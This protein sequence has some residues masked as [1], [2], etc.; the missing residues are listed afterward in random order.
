VVFESVTATG[1]GRNG[2]SLDGSSLADGPNATGTST[3]VYGNNTVSNSTSSG[4]GRYGIEVI[5]GINVVVTGNNLE[6]NVTGIVV[7]DG[8]SAV[9]LQ[10]NRISKGGDQ[11]ISI[12]NA[13][14]DAIVRNNII[15]GGEVGVYVRDAGGTFE[16]NTIQDVSS[17][18]ITLVGATGISQLVGN[19]ISGSGPTALDVARTTDAEVS[20]NATDDWMSTKPID[21]VLR[22]V[23]QPLTVLWLSLG[24]LV[25]FTAVSGVG[26]RRGEI[27]NPYA[28]HA[29]LHT[30][31]R[32]IVSPDELLSSRNEVTS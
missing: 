14:I 7:S 32:G 22:S 30:F 11:G 18:G 23:F 15:I 26:R 24:L 5:G 12:R 3:A 31:T 2:I 6:R 8:A 29:P 13:G 27:V 21:V 16:N 28:T 17:H 1:N 20:K 25:L 19:E 10:N 4:N 9:T